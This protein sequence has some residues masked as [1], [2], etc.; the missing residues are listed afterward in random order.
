[1]DTTV[2][3]TSEHSLFLGDAEFKMIKEEIDYVKHNYT[4]PFGKDI[5]DLCL[6]AVREWAKGLDD[7]DFYTMTY[8]AKKQIA[9]ELKKRIKGD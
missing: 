3:W 1:M 8:A 9:D 2:T 6:N 7:E 5:D 4:D